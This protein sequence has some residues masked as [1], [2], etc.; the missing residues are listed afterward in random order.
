MRLQAVLFG[1][2]RL[3]ARRCELFRRVFLCRDG[4]LRL[5]VGRTELEDVT[6]GWFRL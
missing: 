1:T 6:R 3:Y 2:L 4:D 5:L